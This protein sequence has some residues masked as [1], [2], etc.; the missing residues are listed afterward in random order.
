ME[1]CL[2]EVALTR[3]FRIE[4]LQKIKHERLVD[5]TFGKVGVEVGTLDEAQKEFIDDLQ[6]RPGKFEDR[7]VLFGVIRIAR[8]IDRWGY[9][10]EKVGCKLWSSPLT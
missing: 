8:R 9:R 10:T 6:V 2:Q 7:L 3:I 5:V 1:C 4:Q